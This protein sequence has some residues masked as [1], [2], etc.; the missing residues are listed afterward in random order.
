[1]SGIPYSHACAAIYIHKQRPE[2][3]LDNCYKIEKY[4]Q[5]YVGRVYGIEGPH[6][7]LVDDPCYA[8]LPP[9][10]QMAPRRLKISCK[11]AADETPNP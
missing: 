4:I 2:K 3:W 11:R 6:T 8:I 7:W 1:V 5:G 10:I 9:N